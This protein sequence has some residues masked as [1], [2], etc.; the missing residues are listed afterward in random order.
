MLVDL[1]M[2]KQKLFKRDIVL[3]GLSSKLIHEFVRFLFTYLRA[4]HQHYV[5]TQQ[6]PCSRS[7]FR[8]MFAG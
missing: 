1:G 4:K 7:R 2:L 6:R 3:E 8:C 5:F